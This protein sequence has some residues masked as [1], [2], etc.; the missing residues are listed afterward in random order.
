MTKD[1]IFPENIN[2]ADGKASADV[3]A[4]APLWSGTPIT[5]LL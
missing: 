3:R 1:T 2:Q 4:H 5:S